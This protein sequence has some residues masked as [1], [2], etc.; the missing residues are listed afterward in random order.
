MKKTLRGL[1]R[2]LGFFSLFL[3]LGCQT[4]GGL[5]GL[6]SSVQETLDQAQTESAE[7]SEE[8]T[9]SS[10][11]PG[12]KTISK[13]F[14]SFLFDENDHL[15]ELMD[16]GNFADADRLFVEQIKFF[17]PGGETSAP[18]L[19]R[20]AEA[21]KQQSL[22][23]IENASTKINAFT[24]PVQLDQ[25]P[26]VKDALQSAESSLSNY[27]GDGILNDSRFSV[28]EVDAL[29]SK[30]SEL[31]QTIR[32][33]ATPQFA[34]FDH[35]GD[36]SFFEIYPV[37]LQTT[38][39]ISANYADLT[40][41][42]ESAG[43]ERLQAF[44]RN[45]GKQTLGD[46]RW[47]ALGETYVKAYLREQGGEQD[48]A[49]VLGAMKAAKDAGFEPKVV[50]GLNIGF[51]EIT[52]RTLLKEGQIDFPASIETD[53]PVLVSKADLDDA[54]SS[55][56]TK[57]F[58]YLVIL[59]VALAKASRRVLSLKPIFST[60]LAGYDKIDNPEY[61]VAQQNVEVA[62][63]NFNQASI[64]AAGY[65]GQGMAGAFSQLISG[66]ARGSA[67]GDL[68]KAMQNL[69][70][71]PRTIDEPIYKKYAFKKAAI[72][73]RKM[74]TVHY[75]V[76]DRRKKRYFK[77][78]FDVSEEERFSVA[79]N[80]MSEDPKSDDHTQEYDTEKEVDEFE[81][82]E[83]TVKLSQLIDHYLAN[84]GETTKL[85]SLVTL[86]KEMLKQKNKS[87][88]TFKANTFD[89]RPLNDPRFDNVVAIFTGKGALG[90]GF[91]IKPDVVLTNWHVVEEAKFVE[92]KLY[93]GR[94]TFGKILGKDVRLDLA[95]IKVQHKG[96]PVQF[97]SANIIDVGQTVEAIGHPKGH[98]FT[99][100]RGI[101]SAVRK[102]SSINLPKG[103]GDE[104]LYIQ[105]DAP[106]NPGNSGGPL[107]L[108]DR[109]IGVNTWGL[110]KDVAEGLNFSVHYSEVLEFLREHLPGAQVLT[111]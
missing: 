102:H 72:Q 73:A 78:T 89:A 109:V 74:M 38:E 97:F 45:T 44:S 77:S 107:F 37:E 86:R 60:F 31:Q 81:K 104:V 88:A 28:S 47:A 108:G 13:D 111:N 17:S 56:N 98:E 70:S 41:Q 62:K 65:H 22:P 57:E 32:T 64:Q 20:L 58:D 67:R 101:I 5:E 14:Y 68:Q 63:I 39:I 26:E 9:V 40:I 35:F 93:D 105:T 46:D 50:S 25:W 94:E 55:S 79:Y 51:I 59:D 43:T 18:L 106:I 84:R 23:A 11:E 10:S 33:D 99:I 90:S 110:K 4:D 82:A 100:T 52:S 42:L 95:L 75:Y 49:Q 83:A 16:A 1:Y 12:T 27:P 96:K 85:T 30:L 76:I 7:T 54:L 87:L 2:A 3:I 36:Q 92:M 21:L 19:A 29:R 80:I 91:Y 34:K 48:I 71:T 15:K 61:G 24:W 6:V 69:A 8:Q 53:L 103:A 66:M